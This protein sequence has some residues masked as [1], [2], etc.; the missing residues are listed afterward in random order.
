MV[1]GLASGDSQAK[2]ENRRSAA[3]PE[4][5]ELTEDRAIAA[6]RE[7]ASRPSEC[8]HRDV[9]SARSSTDIEVQYCSVPSQSSATRCVL[10]VIPVRTAARCPFGYVN[11][12]NADSDLGCGRT[13]HPSTMAAPRLVSNSVAQLSSDS[14]L[15]PN[16]E[17]LPISDEVSPLLKPTG[18]RKRAHRQTISER[19]C[20]AQSS[21]LNVN[22]G[23]LLVAASQFFFSA[24]GIAV[25]WLNSLDDPVPTLEVCDHGRVF[26]P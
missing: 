22:S 10:T 21:F 9:R 26:F 15:P 4:G 18:K 2:V 8:G 24:M 17:D 3:V 13:P 23:L 19:W 12:N 5:P 7:S 11:L 1:P 16:G 25:K 6:A 14:D 20:T